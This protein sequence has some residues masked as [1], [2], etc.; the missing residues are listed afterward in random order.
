ML[1]NTH[2]GLLFSP[3]K[4]Q[5]KIAKPNVEKSKV[6]KFIRQLF[7]FFSSFHPQPKVVSGAENG[8]SKSLPR[9]LS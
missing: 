4:G 1:T 7:I 2:V 8:F 5:K 9:I 6:K 3:K